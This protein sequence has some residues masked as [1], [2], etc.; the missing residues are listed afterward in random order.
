MKHSKKGAFATFILLY[1]FIFLSVF[2]VIILINFIFTSYEPSSLIQWVH[3][4][5]GCEVFLLLLKKLYDKKQ[6]AEREQIGLYSYNNLD[7]VNVG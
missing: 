4:F 3:T 2:D 1:C 6:T 5:W 7:D